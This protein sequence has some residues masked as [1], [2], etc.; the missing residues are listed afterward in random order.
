MVLDNDLSEI[1]NLHRELETFGQACGLPRK[2]VSELN[3]VLEEVVANIISY[4]YGDGRRHEIVVRGELKEG[5]LVFEVEDDGRAFNPLEIP[6]PDVDSTLER[7]KV[8]GLGLHLVRKFTNSIE[9]DR[10]EER[11]RLVMRKKI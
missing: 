1:E 10:K 11:N 7:R 2:T 4:S 6:P 5:E 3:L 8:G 9:Y